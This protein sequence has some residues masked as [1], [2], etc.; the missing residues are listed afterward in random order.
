VYRHPLGLPAGSIR[1]ILSLLIVVQFCLYFLLPPHL[2]P[3]PLPVYMYPL[4]LL[5]LLY[6]VFRGKSEPFGAPRQPAPLYLPRGVVRVILFLA[7]AGCVGWKLY[8]DWA[9]VLDRLTPLAPQLAEWPYLVGTFAA[10]F[11]LGR[12]V[13]LG[14][15]RTAAWFQDFLAWVSLIGMIALVAELCLR[16]FVSADYTAELD[17]TLWECV[18]VGIPT[19]YFAARL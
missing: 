11:L 9:Y 4:L 13:R 18:L 5:V 8:E 1:A 19:T 3:G 16:L 12:L 15:W 17:R 2:S 14:P 10:C 6:F 7:L